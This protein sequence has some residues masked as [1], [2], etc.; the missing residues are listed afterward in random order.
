MREE[1]LDPFVHRQQFG[2]WSISHA[3]QIQQFRATCSKM[4]GLTA[5]LFTTTEQQQGK[6]A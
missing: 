2:C 6:A 5:F 3:E 4:E 1:F